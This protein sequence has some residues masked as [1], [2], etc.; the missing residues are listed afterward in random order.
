MDDA[1]ALDCGFWTRDAD[2]IFVGVLRAEVVD[3][4]GVRFES[5]DLV[6]RRVGVATDA[7][8][9]AYFCKVSTNAMDSGTAR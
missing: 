6:A 8:E 3:R 1:E 7:S 2:S 9:N 4:G 5:I